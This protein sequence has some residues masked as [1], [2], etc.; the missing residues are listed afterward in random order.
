MRELYIVSIKRPHGVSKAE[1]R[2]YMKG[3]IASWSGGGCPDSL[4]FGWFSQKGNTVHIDRPEDTK[5]FVDR[6]HL[7]FILKKETT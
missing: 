6:Q 2:E 4:L 7:K 1:M 3:A 5:H